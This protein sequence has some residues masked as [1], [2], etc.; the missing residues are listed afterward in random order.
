MPHLPRPA[1]LRNIIHRGLVVLCC[2]SAPVTATA[3]FLRD[4]GALGLSYSFR[5]GMDNFDHL[6]GDP[7]TSSSAVLDSTLSR[8]SGNGSSASDAPM[9]TDHLAIGMATGRHMLGY[10][11][12]LRTAAAHTTVPGSTGVKQTVRDTPNGTYGYTRDIE[13][14]LWWAFILAGSS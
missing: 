5:M 9:G 1:D 4:M 13:N 6:P 8:I 14:N 3:Y 10:A 11:Q 2:L 12:G 7:F